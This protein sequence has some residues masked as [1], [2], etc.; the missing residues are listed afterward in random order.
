MVNILT[1]LIQ[2]YSRGRSVAIEEDIEEDLAD[3]EHPHYR[4]PRERTHDAP[5]VKSNDMVVLEFDGQK[6][7]SGKWDGE[8]QH[9]YGR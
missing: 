7:K 3:H 2:D 6:K 4:T 5:S 8:K 1:C 9:S